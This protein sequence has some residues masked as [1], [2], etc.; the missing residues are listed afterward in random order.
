M[1]NLKA[2]VRIFKNNFR[3]NNKIINGQPFSTT[4]QQASCRDHITKSF[5]VGERHIYAFLYVGD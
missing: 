5:K 2:A 3:K 4:F 1:K